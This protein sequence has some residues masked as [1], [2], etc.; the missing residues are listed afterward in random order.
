M[1]QGNLVINQQTLRKR[2]HKSGRTWRSRRKKHFSKSTKSLDS[3][4]ETVDFMKWL[5]LCGLANPFQIKLY[6][7]SGQGRALFTSKSCI[8]EN[9]KVFII[10]KDLIISIRMIRERH[11]KIYENF[12]FTDK[13]VYFLLLQRRLGT[14]SKFY[15]YL[16]ILPAFGTIDL[17][18]L[19][20]WERVE[21]Y[22]GK[23]P[24]L[25]VDKIHHL[26]QRLQNDYRRFQK[27]LGKM[28]DDS[29]DY[30]HFLLA[31]LCVNTRCVAIGVDGPD[32]ISIVPFFDMLNH[33]SSAQT[34]IGL[35][36]GNFFV[37][38]QSRIGRHEQ[39]HL[40]YSHESNH[41]FVYSYGFVPSALF[42]VDHRE[43]TIR[44]CPNQHDCI[45]IPLE[46]LKHL[47]PDL[48][49]RISRIKT[50]LEYNSFEVR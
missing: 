15:L 22:R 36:D 27:S 17:P 16:N 45:E 42:N 4:A 23:A 2:K 38:T 47:Y 1:D 41:H 33:S 28:Q 9:E 40:C 26:S 12:Y 29:V 31:Y 5:S 44:F 24:D 8:P 46:M 7:V 37:E 49:V 10:P 3:S 18:A 43:Q 25:V 13:L 50:I 21:A 30:E 35:K 19:W 39:I 14:R 20:P 11:P 48:N 6:Q 34:K 32:D